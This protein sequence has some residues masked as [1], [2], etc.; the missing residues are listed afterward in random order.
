MVLNRD[1]LLGELWAAYPDTIFDVVD[2]TDGML[3]IN[4]RG[5]WVDSLNI[6]GKHMPDPDWGKVVDPGVPE[7]IPIQ[8]RITKN[9]YVLRMENGVLKTYD[10]DDKLV[11]KIWEFWK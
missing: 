5:P 9:Q 2:I 1:Q 11:K 8:D 10:M 7:E 3:A 6:V 4:T